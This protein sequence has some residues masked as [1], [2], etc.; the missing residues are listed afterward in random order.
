M[1]EQQMD[2]TASLAAKE[3]GMAVALTKHGGYQAWFRKHVEDMADGTLFTSEDVT[4]AIGLPTRETEMNKNNSVGA[5]MAGLAKDGTIAHTGSRVR[6]KRVSSHGA[7]LV[8]WQRTYGGSGRVGSQVQ[9]APRSPQSDDLEARVEA[10]DVVLA[11]LATEAY[12]RGN[13]DGFQRGY[14]QG[15]DA[16]IKRPGALKDAKHEGVIEGRRQQ[17]ARTMALIT[18]MRASMKGRGPVEAHSTTCWQR[19]P[20][21]AIDSIRKAQ[22]IK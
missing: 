22:E 8:V 2:L 10:A 18:E 21:C 11:G 1:T 4:E 14:E 19:H 20:M 16:A 13:D 3:E 17:A 9:S 6:S 12:D 7:E 15:I 5:L